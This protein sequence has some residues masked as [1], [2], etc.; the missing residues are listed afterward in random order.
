MKIH[1]FLFTTAL[2]LAASNAKAEV[3]TKELT[4]KEGGTELQG[5]VAFDDAAK[6]KRP[7][8]LIVHEWWG[9][10]EHARN[11]A[12][13]LAKEG[14]V[15]FALDM[16]GKGKLAKHP[17][18]AQAFMTEAKKDAAKQK[19]RFMAAL[20]MLKKQPNVDPEKIGAVGYCFGGGVVLD[21]ARAGV[22]LDAVVSIHGALGTDKP[23]KK[24]AVKPQVVVLT[25]A[26]DPMIGKDQVDAFKKEMDAAG[27]KYEVVAYPHAQHSFTNPD[28]D[29]A[30][31]QGLA[32]N[33][34]A[35][36]KSFDEMVKA[37]KKAFGG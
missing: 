37:F 23:A 2:V 34:E 33:A 25:G 27:A 26:D 28:A 9:H 30:G 13:R 19:A 8:V 4:Y 15:A 36:K 35:D 16:Y 6:G 18:E 10:N 32:Y 5:F 31:V 21:M 7:G 20:E 11:Q 17:E 3:Q 1:T 29:K 14:F 24:G 12:K 22:D